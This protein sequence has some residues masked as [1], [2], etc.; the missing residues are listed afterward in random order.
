MDFLG[1]RPRLF[2]RSESYVNSRSSANSRCFQQLQ[3]QSRWKEGSCRRPAVPMLK[4]LFDRQAGD[5]VPKFAWPEFVSCAPVEVAGY[6]KELVGQQAL[7]RQAQ[8]VCRRG[9]RDRSV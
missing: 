9:R 7:A 3:Q 4:A 5:S 8:S 2:A 6:L 1:G